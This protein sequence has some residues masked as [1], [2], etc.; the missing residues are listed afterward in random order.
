MSHAVTS[1]IIE[2]ENALVEV[3]RNGDFRVISEPRALLYHRHCFRVEII[4]EAV[5]L[6]FRFPL[7]FRTSRSDD[8]SGL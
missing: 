2:I 6:Y 5:W 7:S 3:L 8:A 4:A 1:R